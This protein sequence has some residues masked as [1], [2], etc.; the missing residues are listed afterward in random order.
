MGSIQPDNIDCGLKSQ[1]RIQAGPKVRMD[2]ELTLILTEWQYTAM[3]SSNV[4]YRENFR[5]VPIH[6]EPQ[7]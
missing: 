3:Q 4:W 1:Y 6:V 5:K 2:P 7:E